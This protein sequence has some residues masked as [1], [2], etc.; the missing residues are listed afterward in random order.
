[1]FDNDD[2]FDGFYRIID[3]LKGQ[4]DDRNYQKAEFGVTIRDVDATV[5][6]TPTPL[7]KPQY[8]IGQILTRGN[9]HKTILEAT[10]WVD[11]S[12]V[13]DPFVPS[14][15][16]LGDMDAVEGLRAQVGYR[17]IEDGVLTESDFKPNKTNARGG[18]F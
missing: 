14:I 2:H 10:L 1:M 7:S 18:W 12:R 17:L 16:G 4:Y 6:V 13:G 11:G 9:E 15:L 3:S 8:Y 5:K